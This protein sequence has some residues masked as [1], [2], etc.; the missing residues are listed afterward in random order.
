MSKEVY[1]LVPVKVVVN[2]NGEII[3]LVEPVSLDVCESSLKE[4]G[5]IEADGF[6][7]VGILSP[8]SFKDLIN[9]TPDMESK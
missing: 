1:V 6:T 8:D 5:Y 3:G 7:P 9:K 2:N 4:L